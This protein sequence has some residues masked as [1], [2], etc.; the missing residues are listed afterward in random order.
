MSTLTEAL[1]SAKKE[2][3]SQ[4]IRLRDLETLLNEER[5][6]REDAEERANR[7]E[8]ESIKEHEP[9]E[10]TLVD[11]EDND[12][13]NIPRLEKE[14]EAK[15]AN[16]SASPTLADT[17]AARLQQ[18]LEL[19]M[20]E[21]NEMK[22]QMERYRERAETAEADRKSLA[23]MIES[24]RQDNAEPANT[25]AKHSSSSDNEAIR[26]ATD[27]TSINGLEDDEGVDEGD[28]A[29]INEKDTGHEGGSVLLRRA[30]QNG[31]PVVQDNTD[32][33][34]TSQ[35]VT[36]QLPRNSVTLA[37]GAPAMSILAVVAMGVAV[38]AYLN[39]LPK[40]ER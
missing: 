39:S 24:I 26:E 32:P 7:L 37:S 35:A 22:Q 17:T 9:S 3:E 8:R 38:M 6:A 20:T 33:K 30:M 14:V 23:E 29:I 36:S 34:K 18:R 2:I 31:R 19:M 25:E 10:P 1:S 13:E 27:T 5:R 28:V 11:V 40:V 12:S 21:M 16:G 15:L 4:G